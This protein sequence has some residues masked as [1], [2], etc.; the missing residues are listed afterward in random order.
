MR[1]TLMPI[2]DLAKYALQTTS[3]SYC[4][5]C[6]AAAFLLAPRITPGRSDQWNEPWFYLCA[7][8]GAVAQVGVGPVV[9]PEPR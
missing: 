3:K 7:A 1:A 9:G 5:E 6:G 8:C 2:I 4:G